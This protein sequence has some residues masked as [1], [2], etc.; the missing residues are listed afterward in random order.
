MDGLNEWLIY[1][2]RE[3][4]S[5]HES[6]KLGLLLFTSLC[7]HCNSL[8][9][10]CKNKKGAHEAIAV[11]VTDVFTTFWRPLWSVTEQTHGNMES[12]CFIQKKT[13]NFSF[14]FQ[15]L[16]QLLESRFAHLSKHEKKPFDVIC[17][18]DQ[19]K[20]RHCQTWFKWLLVEWKLTARAELNCE[21]YKC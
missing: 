21:I 12:I 6:D 13:Y 3:M 9:S 2:T 11:C 10:K 18:L 8:T 19:E 14:L 4:G 15:N 20:S 17:C 5:K 1:G 7:S 16:S